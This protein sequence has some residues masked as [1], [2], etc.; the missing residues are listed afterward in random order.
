[1][2]NEERK[3]GFIDIA[4]QFDTNAENYLS[5]LF[6]NTEQLEKKWEKDVCDFSVD[7]ISIYLSSRLSRSYITLVNVVGF[8]KRY[9]NYCMNRMLVVDNQNHFE[10]F[11]Q[12]MIKQCISSSLINDLYIPREDLI[13]LLSSKLIVN[14]REKFIMLAIYEGIGGGS[15]EEL[16]N[17]KLVDFC[18]N[19]IRISHEKNIEVSDELV[20]LAHKADETLIEYSINATPEELDHPEDIKYYHLQDVDYIVKPRAN[21]RG[22]KLT[23]SAI[24]VMLNT[25]CSKLKTNALSIHSLKIS[26]IINEV[27]KYMNE[28]GTTAKE[29][30]TDSDFTNTLFNRYGKFRSDL[31]LVQYSEIYNK[32]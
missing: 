32:Q 4:K 17:L 6:K 9:T 2:Y 15:L 18:G 11:N 29:A 1:M 22:D 28:N 31:H 7:Q 23:Y 30:F 10:E 24:K 19:V 3:Q 14:P 27:K 16:I 21:G 8:L 12:E 26:G 20:Q 13:E 5:S 25:Y